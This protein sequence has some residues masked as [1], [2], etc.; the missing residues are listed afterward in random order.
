MGGG[1]AC[2][3]VGRKNEEERRKKNEEERRRRTT[4]NK[5][6]NITEMM[7]IIIRLISIN[8]TYIIYLLFIFS[9]LMME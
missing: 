4:R 2:T 6:N 8:M 3:G 1:V 7:N 5:I 9:I